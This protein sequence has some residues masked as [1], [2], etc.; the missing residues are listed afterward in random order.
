MKCNIRSHQYH[1]TCPCICMECSINLPRTIQHIRV[2]TRSAVFNLPSTTQEVHVHTRTCIAAFGFPRAVHHEIHTYE[3]QYSHCPIH[4]QSNMFIQEQSGQ[5]F[6]LGWQKRYLRHSKIIQNT[7]F[8]PSQQKSLKHFAQNN[9]QNMHFP[10][11]SKKFY[12]KLFPQTLHIYLSNFFQT[13]QL[14][15][16]LNCNSI[17]NL[18]SDLVFF[19]FQYSKKSF[20]VALSLPLYLLL[21][22]LTSTT[23]L[24]STT[25]T[26]SD[27]QTTS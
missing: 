24:P 1:P 4:V 14:N 11:R 9:S 2:H 23:N 17:P 25:G 16:C 27:L 20:Q 15:A 18:T 12:M 3:V 19:F 26:I 10:K 8:T 6:K 22:A 21:T 13:T 5:V 7:K